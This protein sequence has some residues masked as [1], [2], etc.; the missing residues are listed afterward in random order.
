M[1]YDLYWENVPPEIE[2]E[3]EQAREELM[4]AVKERDALPWGSD[5][6]KKLHEEKVLPLIEKDERTHKNY[7]RLNIWGMGVCRRL[8]DERE[9]LEWEAHPGWPTR[10]EF[11]VPE[12]L[13]GEIRLDDEKSYD[14]KS[15]AGM[16]VAAMKHVLEGDTGGP[17]PAYKL[18]DNSGWL[19]TPEEIK[20]SLAA[21]G[22]NGGK[23][24]DAGGVTTIE[25]GEAAEVEWWPEW[26]AWLEEAAKHGGFRVY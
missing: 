20:R 11:G 13:A 19:V 6:S 23:E 15:P 7:F 9:M 16:Y 3:H 21:Y 24:A 18:S 12:E 17:M 26:I 10:E 2:K 14:P 1:G 4:A 22:E 5:E 25:D 8:M